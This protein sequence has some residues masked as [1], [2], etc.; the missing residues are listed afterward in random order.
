MYGLIT[1]ASRT[2]AILG[3]KLPKDYEKGDPVSVV[4]EKL[5]SALNPIG[6]DYYYL[7]HC[8]TPPGWASTIGYKALTLGETLSGDTN[9]LTAY[10][11]YFLED[12]ECVEL[13]TSHI[14]DKESK[15]YVQLINEGYEVALSADEL[16]TAVSLSYSDG[17]QLDKLFTFNAADYKP[18]TVSQKIHISGVPLG[19]MARDGKSAVVVN[20]LV[21]KVFYQHI[22]SGRYSTRDV[23]RVVGLEVAPVSV[24]DCKQN[25]SSSVSVESGKAS[26][27]KYTY[28]VQFI[29]SDIEYATRW[30]A[31]LKASHEE[32]EIHWR[33]LTDSIAVTVTLALMTG[34]ILVRTVHQDIS[35]YNDLDEDSIEVERGWKLLH[36]DVFR[37]PWG[38]RAL[39]GLVGSGVQVFSASC[40]VIVCGALGIVSPS[41]RGSIIQ[42]LVILFTLFGVPAGYVAARLN[43]IFLS[44]EVSSARSLVV[45]GFTAIVY[46]GITFVLY[47]VANFVILVKGGASVPVLTVIVLGF[48]W[49]FISIP[50]TVVGAYFGYRAAPIEVPC[51]VNRLPRQIPVVPWFKNRWLLAFL[52]GVP[53]LSVV[54]TEIRCTV[55]SM[56]FHNFYF[57]I[58]YI[59]VSFIL[60]MITTILVS[61]VTTYMILV[62]EDYRWWFPSFCVG[63]GTALHTFIL[64]VA[65]FAPL[66]GSLSSILIDWAYLMIGSITIGIMLGSV[67][68]VT[69]FLFVKKIFGSIKVD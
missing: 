23:Y 39:A 46:P 29:E 16:P 67:S 44:N 25:D 17:D 55:V 56:V 9:Q 68:L 8:P 11:L 22:E 51:R 12:Q 53:V 14:S 63:A 30:D 59:V 57:L 3:V 69:S 65:I 64:G 19:Q 37:R 38:S 42:A 18:E 7:P 2:Y 21:Y 40:I 58:G 52:S 26:T 1:L 4:S 62:S 35:R 6:Y 33:A 34:V 54:V 24:A 15:K 28:S 20:H 47:L 48:L 27:I 61:I 45:T 66:Y 36:G 13:C 43:R 50:L 5:S 49:F 32:S 31:Y 41:N 10:S 60:M